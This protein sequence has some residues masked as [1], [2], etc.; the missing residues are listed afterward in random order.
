MTEDEFLDKSY[1]RMD[2][3]CSQLDA[4]SPG[5]KEYAECYDEL[6]K[7]NE[8]VGK[9]VD[10]QMRRAQ[11][12]HDQVQAKN[13]LAIKQN[14]IKVDQAKVEAENRKSKLGLIGTIAT[15]TATVVTAGLA[16]WEGVWGTKRITQY[17]ETGAVTSKAY[18][19]TIHKP[20]W[21]N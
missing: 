16:T 21:K 19:G 14:Q 9:V 8:Q 15:V 7:I 11:F 3:L 12:S 17:E 5:Q 4:L 13:D 20:K 18:N 2:E 6:A 1:A 10:R